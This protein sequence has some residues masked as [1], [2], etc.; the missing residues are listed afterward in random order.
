MAI[1]TTGTAHTLVEEARA[2]VRESVSWLLDQQHPEGCW[3]AQVDSDASVTAQYLLAARYLGRLDPDVETPMLDYLRSAQRPDGGWPMYPG[4]PPSLDVSLLCYAALKFAGHPAQGPDLERARRMI[5]ARGGL[6]AVGFVPRA[7]L[8]MWG[9]VPLD[10]LT[11]VSPKLLLVPP[12]VSPNLRDLGIFLLAALPVWVLA[13]E[14]R[15]QV[16]PEGCDLAELRT[17]GRFP[18]IS[19]R[20]SNFAVSTVSRWVDAVLPAPRLDR[21]ATDWLVERQNSDG[22]WA[23]PA[24]FTNRV[25]MALAAVDARRYHA[26]IAAGLAGL[27][28]LHVSEG[29]TRW[30][31]IG[32][33]P[34]LDT[35]IAVA[36]LIEAG[37]R[38]DSP[39]LR[40]AFDW[41]IAVQARRPG[42]WRRNAPDVL[43]GGWGFSPEN[44]RTPDADTTLHVLEALALAPADVP[45][46]VEALARGVQYLLGMQNRN[47]SWGMF[48][49]APGLRLALPQELERHGVMDTGTP[50]VTS[51]AI[52]ALASLR[53]A[54]GANL[55][56]IRTA[57]ARGLRFLAGVQGVDGAWEGRW[58]VNYVYG[59][60]QGLTAFA[61][62][63]V[64]P[65][66]DVPASRRA[67][68]FLL[69]TQQADG[70]WG[71]SP[72]S[73]AE[74]RFIPAPSTITQTGLVLLALL[75]AH[76]GRPAGP[77]D[78][79]IAASLRFVLDRRDPFRGVWD[80][81]TFCQT[82]LPNNLY[83]QNSLF[84][85]CLAQMA[86][87]RYL[88][89]AGPA[90]TMS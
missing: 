62:A 4:G 12:A 16:P 46:R 74:G 79:A 30:Q 36:S 20:P 9:Q 5:L 27:A 63:A 83:F 14:R 28:R 69:A 55:P 24:P 85:T 2:A 82:I 32:R 21:V 44:D 56:D 81:Q 35:A 19:M 87:G 40:A 7:P 53:T 39:R 26:P 84:A 45:G 77:A 43:H 48:N 54:S 76:A 1:E 10:A 89:A 29:P 60:A 51:R 13:K 67:R 68:G 52:R 65:A 41:L 18:A 80:E 49:R 6:E 50:D 15:V 73:H 31:Q 33:S 37:L 47:G 58:A 42:D 17:G 71:E 59:T 61:A 23:G 34:V 22:L 64:A 25:L 90:G 3:V 66:P 11:Y 38:P 88:H 70:G 72:E 8:A 75:A 57:V 86:L 78:P